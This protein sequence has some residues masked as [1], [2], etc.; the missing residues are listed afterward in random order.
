MQQAV[1]TKLMSCT[2]EIDEVFHTGGTGESAAAVLVTAEVNQ[3]ARSM[4]QKISWLDLCSPLFLAIIIASNYY[5]YC[6]PSLSLPNP[7]D[8]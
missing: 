8:I 6:V 3:L 1:L 7:L 4:R 5:F 2:H